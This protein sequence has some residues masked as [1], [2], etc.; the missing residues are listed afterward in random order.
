MTGI[1]QSPV[2]ITWVVI[3]GSTDCAPSVN[4]L[5]LRSTCGIGL[6]ATKPSFLLFVI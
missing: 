2:K 1:D 5:M 4:E 3:D 6:A